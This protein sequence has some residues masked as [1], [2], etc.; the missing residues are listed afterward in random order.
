MSEPSPP[1]ARVARQWTDGFGRLAMRSLQVLIVVALATLVVVAGLALKVVVI[2]VLIALILASAFAPLV[3]L[4]ERIRLPR[5]PAALVTLVVVIGVL[6][7]VLALVVLAVVN[8]ASDL[9][10]AVSKGIDQLETVLK[11]FGITISATQ[12]QKALSAAGSYLTSASFGSSALSGLSAAGN[13]ATG[14]VLVVFVLFFFLRDGR[15]IW[16]FLTRPLRGAARA[17]AE[18]I[19]TSSTVVLGAYARGTTPPPRGGGAPR[20][21]PPRRS[22]P[23]TRC[24]SAPAC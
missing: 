1:P 15:R 7:G 18:R 10:D 21:G 16:D 2:S 11:G 3:R 4:L 17:R 14:L 8:Q 12:V 22:P 6:L 24:S 23:S 19:G 20:G 13:F 5:T 9:T